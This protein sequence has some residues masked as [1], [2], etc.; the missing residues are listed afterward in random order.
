MGMEAD[1]RKRLR[2]WGEWLNYDANIG[3]PPDRCS[4]KAMLRVRKITELDMMADT[5]KQ[6]LGDGA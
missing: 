5:I 3:P 4:S 2:N 1:L 6:L